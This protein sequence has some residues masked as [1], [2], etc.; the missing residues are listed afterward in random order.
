MKK[1]HPTPLGKNN[2]RPQPTKNPKNGFLK[3]YPEE[4]LAFFKENIL[5][6]LSAAEEELQ[7][8]KGEIPEKDGPFD[9]GEEGQYGSAMTEVLGRISR[10][11]KYIKCLKNALIRIQ[12]GNYGVCRET[13]ELIPKERLIV[14]P[15]ATLCKEAKNNRDY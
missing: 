4:E 1:N 6:K 3:K 8:L 11:H 5:G 15:H 9:K 10:Q 13:G 2:S 12:Q 14:V 7:F